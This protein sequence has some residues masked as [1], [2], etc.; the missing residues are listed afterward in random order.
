[1]K[2]LN[3]F[4]LV[5]ITDPVLAAMFSGCDVWL[6]PLKEK[7]KKTPINALSEYAEIEYELDGENAF[8]GDDWYIQNECIYGY[9]SGPFAI[10]IPIKRFNA[11]FCKTKEFENV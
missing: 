8:L 5:L 6:I 7:V 10:G 2:K 11:R 3:I 1:M 4:K 9:N